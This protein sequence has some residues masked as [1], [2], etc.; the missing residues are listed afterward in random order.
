MTDPP[1]PA[2]SARLKRLERQFLFAAI[3][4]ALFLLAVPHLG[5]LASPLLHDLAL[6]GASMLLGVSIG[7][8]WARRLILTKGPRREHD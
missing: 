2:L 5:H 7:I 8:G 4:A 1:P 3:I 6:Q